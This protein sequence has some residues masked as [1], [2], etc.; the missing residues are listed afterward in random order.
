MARR[1]ARDRGTVGRKLLAL[2][3]IG[4]LIYWAGRDPAGAAHAARHVAE[5][6]TAFARAI[7]HR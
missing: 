6:V 4:G 3:A 7:R 1:T 5:A 2:L